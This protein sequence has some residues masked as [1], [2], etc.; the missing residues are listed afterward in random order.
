MTQLPIFRLHQSCLA[1]KREQNSRNR[2]H[3]GL[4]LVFQI[5]NYQLWQL[6]ILL[7]PLFCLKK[8]TWNL[9]PLLPCL[10][11]HIFALRLQQSR[12][13]VRQNCSTFDAEKIFL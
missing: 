2:W 5:V 4:A 11:I 8:P 3:N 7:P 12:V 13:A 1:R 9:Q 10:T 6:P